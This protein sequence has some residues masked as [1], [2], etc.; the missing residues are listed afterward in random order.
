MPEYENSI[1]NPKS[2]TV[3]LTIV[4]LVLAALVFFAIFHAS[5]SVGPWPADSS[6]YW[7]MGVVG[8]LLLSSLP[9]L[10]R[11]Y[12][13]SSALQRAFPNEP[14]RWNPAWTTNRV[15]N[16]SGARANQL[17][18]S[19]VFFTLMAAVLGWFMVSMTSG[20]IPNGK[21]DFFSLA[22]PSFAGLAAL[23]FT[24][25]AIRAKLQAQRFGGSVLIMESMPAPI[26]GRLVGALEIPE[27]LP[28]TTPIDL[29]LTCQRQYTDSTTDSDGRSHS[30]THY[31]T[32]WEKKLIA[33]P[34]AHLRPARVAIDIPIPIEVE[35]TTRLGSHDGVFWKLEAKAN[36]SGPDLN[37]SFEIPVFRKSV[38]TTDIS[39]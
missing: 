10:W 38:N 17:A 33:S 24:I 28:P 39:A 18:W 12:R 19:A 6:W 30:N 21:P 2:A 13:S 26:G 1:R 16:G 20:L 8:L 31:Q 22:I 37:V 14:W 5:T 23:G 34:Q 3:G 7:P 25:A 4:L 35:P 29:R 27:A 11:G 15:S 36:L 9:R 32:L